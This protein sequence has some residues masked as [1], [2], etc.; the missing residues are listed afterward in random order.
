MLR[1]RPAAAAR[2][3]L[4]HSRSRRPC[5]LLV[6]CGLRPGPPG[7]QPAGPP[8]AARAASRQ[9]ASAWPGRYRAAWYWPGTGWP[10]R[11]LRISH[12]LRRAA[13]PASAR[14]AASA[15]SRPQL[16]MDGAGDLQ[17]GIEL[18][19]GPGGGDRRLVR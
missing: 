6:G 5:L 4:A 2:L 16:V 17:A 10:G 8:R 13:R 15:G 19:P 1:D 9:P 3:V 7:A 14:L 18:L 11:T 12:P